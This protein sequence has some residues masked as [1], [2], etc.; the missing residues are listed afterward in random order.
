[1]R[2]GKTS[3][4]FHLIFRLL[5]IF[6][7]FVIPLKG[8][9][10]YDYEHYVPPFYNGSNRADDVGRHTVVLST[11][12]TNYVNVSIFKGDGTLLHKA[13]PIKRGE[14]YEYTFE[15]PK[16]DNY[17]EIISYPSSYDFPYGVVGAPEIN[18]PL[19]N[20]GLRFYSSDG[21]FFVNIRHVSGVHGG[22]L[23]AKGTYA[24][25]TDFYSGHLYN[26][27]LPYYY[28][29]R[30][31][32]FISV[33]ATEDTDVTFSDIKCSYLSKYVSGNIELEPVARADERTVSL[34]KGQS[35]VIAVDF[36][37]PDFYNNSSNW[38]GL[39]GTHITSTK[40]IVVNAG[41]WTAGSSDS[42]EIGIDQ[43]VPVDQ[44][45]DKYVVMRGKGTDIDQERTV[46]VATEANT[47]VWVNGEL[48]T[49]LAKSG[50]FVVLDDMI[51]SYRDYYGR[52]RYRAAYDNLYI[53]TKDKSVY[54]YQSMCGDPT[55]TN[56]GLNFIPPLTATGMKEV[57]I[58]FADYLAGKQVTDAAITILTQ[59]NTT[60]DYQKTVGGVTTYHT[61]SQSDAIPINGTTEWVSY[62]VQGDV[63]GNYRFNSGKA[64]NVAWTVRSGWVGA[65][66]YYSGFT[67]AISKIIPHLDIN[68][69]TDLGVLCESY[70]GEQ[71][72]V[73]VNDTPM[74]DFY[75]WYVDDFSKPPIVT[76]QPLVVDVPDKQT[77]YHVIGSYRDPTLDILFNG[78]FSDGYNG[79][80]SDYELVVK[81]LQ[82]PGQFAIAKTPKSEN[83]ALEDFNAMDGGNMFVAYSNNRN[84]VVYQVSEI[85]V[86]SNF[87]YIFRLNGRLANASSTNKQSLK[88]VINSDTIL[89]NFLLERTDEWK[90]ES[91]LWKSKT[92]KKATIKILNNNLDSDDTYFAL[93]SISFVQAVQD[94]AVFVAKV[95]PNY[96]YDN[97]GKTFHFCKGEQN[98]LDVSN[99]DTS[100]YTYAWSKKNDS[101]GFDALVNGDDYTG[102]DT[103]E[104]I[105]KNPTESQ[106]GEYRC[107]IGFKEEYQ[108]CGTSLAEVHADLQVLVDEAATVDIQP[109]NSGVC[110]GNSKELQAVVT[111]ANEAVKWYIK[112]STDADYPADPIATGLNFTMET[113]YTAGVYNVKCIAVNGCGS[114]EDV[115]TVE[116]LKA[117]ELTGL[118]VNSNLCVGQDIVLTA[119]ASGSGTLVYSW[120]EGSVDL[121]ET[122]NILTIPASLDKKASIFSVGVTSIYNI[123]GVDVSCPAPN[124]ES[125]D[126]LDILP[127]VNITSPIVDATLCEE[128][129]NHIFKVDTE[130]DDSYYTFSWEHKGVSIDGESGSQL[131][132]SPVTNEDAGDYKVIISN[133][134]ETKESTANLI[135]TDK[136]VVNGITS[137]LDGPF[138]NPTN[139]TVTFD[140]TGDVS[141]YRLKTPDGVTND[142]VLVGNTYTF[143]VNDATKGAYEFSVVPICVGEPFTKTMQFDM[144]PDFGIL[145]VNDITTCLGE[146]VAFIADVADVSPLSVLTYEWKDKDNHV[147]GGNSQTLNIN[148]V[149]D[150]NLG[151]YTCKVTDQ[152]GRSKTVTV[153]I[154]TPPS[155]FTTQRYF[156]PLYV[157]L[158]ALVSSN[159]SVFTPE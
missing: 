99:G 68:L 103:H 36:D 152:C 6:S 34:K 155:V 111:G 66:G 21:P 10:Q 81:N 149:T 12:S 86:E 146:N 107:A 139:V 91:A 113:S 47:E 72:K 20:Q 13:Q 50:D 38:N 145:S 23:T 67:K 142:I 92:N 74:P 94:T 109:D 31:S 27:A 108:D 150:A 153:A 89:K 125:K 126:N 156:L 15:T 157:A 71:I 64:I 97:N 122:G 70:E 133:R 51:E 17:G 28:R 114:L 143:E 105:F 69:N 154:H 116:V 151:S 85:P 73:S 18:K 54:V 104:L 78:D 134:C 88:V 41:S 110:E 55:K 129:A 58:P 137:D 65:A 59:K 84:E 118:D 158:S 130:E 132:I 1:M 119:N 87:N 80:D 140:V 75:E 44:M 35:Y 14:P 30:R 39:N 93:D 82:T 2:H 22:S 62:V 136:M 83:P 53:D 77:D 102:V 112:K 11:N 144:I 131:L 25:G 40:P 115:A 106:E 16:G 90:A 79:Y 5:F 33:M 148:N 45:R 147:V 159:L 48:V 19:D 37:F 128:T 29:D 100:W 95:V 120:K 135:V 117:P 32:H 42:Q 57:T 60:V 9:A 101:G 138:C 98:S 3:T 141:S 7:F 121:T 4:R 26:H 52:L 24:K 76:N 61:L 127:G 63:N 46:V 8:L 96:S 43:I 124:R 123:G 49:T 56:I